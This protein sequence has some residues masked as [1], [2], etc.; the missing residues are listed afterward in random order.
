MEHPMIWWPWR[1]LH[2]LYL[3]IFVIHKGEMIMAS[4]VS[5]LDTHAPLQLMA[6]YVNAKGKVVPGPAN[7]SIVWSVADAN[8]PP[9]ESQAPAGSQDI[10]T[11]TGS[12]GSFSVNVTDGT[13]SDSLPVTVTPDQTP[14]G[15]QIVLQNP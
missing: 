5:V 2:R 9:I 10:V 15:I 13:F 8:T 11:L 1:P 3:K 6:Q 12:D 14:T 7:P 4:A